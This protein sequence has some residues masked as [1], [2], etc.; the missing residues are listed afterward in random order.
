MVR[1][2]H[3]SMGSM[4]KLLLKVSPKRL[5]MT[6]V[7]DIDCRFF[8]R[9]L[10]YSFHIPEDRNMSGIRQGVTVVR[11]YVRWTKTAPDCQIIMQSLDRTV[12]ET[13]CATSSVLGGYCG[14][15]K[16]I[17]RRKA[18]EVWK[19]EFV[20]EGLK[21][22]FLP[23]TQS[24]LE[25]CAFVTKVGL[26]L[27][28]VVTYIPLQEL[29]FSILILMKMRMYACLSSPLL[30]QAAVWPL[31]RVNRFQAWLGSCCRVCNP[32]FAGTGNMYHLG[33]LHLGF[34]CNEASTKL[35]APFSKTVL[36]G[37]LREKYR[38][39]NMVFALVGCPEVWVSHDRK[40]LLADLC[41]VLSN[42][43]CVDG[44]SLEHRVEGEN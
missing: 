44:W 26:Q 19:V 15:G 31:G 14:R 16:M 37:M 24:F 13:L 7:E 4:L 5:L 23:V 18:K 6:C 25:R 28:R 38:S 33:K 39:L 17:A 11:P 30:Q 1:I 29:H 36:Q 9:T 27:Y 43:Q 3:E 10:S 42:C 2:V 22:L 41:D 20:C 32:A 12:P 35:I 21:D 40:T 8:P 34:S